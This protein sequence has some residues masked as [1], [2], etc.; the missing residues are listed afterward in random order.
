MSSE[1][2]INFAEKLWRDAYILPFIKAAQIKGVGKFLLEQAQ[3]IV[4]EKNKIIIYLY[5][6]D[7]HLV[8]QVIMEK[9]RS[10]INAYWETDYPLTIII[11]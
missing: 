10:S 2:E 8:T 1:P 3:D 6:K 9:L 7:Q 4:L 11:I 5:E